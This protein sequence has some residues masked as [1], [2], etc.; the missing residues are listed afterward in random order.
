MDYFNITHLFYKSCRAFPDRFAIVEENNS[1]TYKKLEAD[2]NNTIAYFQKKGI[3]K[4]DRILVFVGMGIDLYRIVLAIFTMGAVAVFVDEW[5]SIQRLSL[6]CLMADCKAVIAPLQYRIAGLF[7]KGIRSI[8]IFLSHN[9]MI[10]NFDQHHIENTISSDPALI[11][12]TTGSTGIPKAVERSHAFLKSQFDELTPLIRGTFIMTTLPIV[13]LLNLGLGITSFIAKFNTKNSAGFDAHKI[14]S[15]INKYSIDCIITSPFYLLK[16]AECKHRTSNLKYIIS[17][18]AAIFSSDAEKIVHVFSNALFTVVYGSTEAEPISHCYADELINSKN[19]FGVQVGKPVQSIQLKIIPDDVPPQVSEDDLDKLELSQGCI[20]EIIVSGDTVNKS[21]LHNHQAIV[22]NKIVT[23]KNVWHRTGD[24][25][26]IDISGNLFL[27]GRVSQIIHH[28]NKTYYPFV[29]ENYLKN[30]NGVKFGTLLLVNNTLLL[31]L[32]VTDSF[33][34]DNVSGF[35]Y[36]E[37]RYLD[38]FP[39]DPRHHSK[40][41]YLKLTT[42]LQ[43]S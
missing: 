26:Y 19:N 18:G 28:N 25:G 2:V 36:D 14:L 3:K 37:I 9:T 20:G 16:M 42:L 10:L 8:P 30:I 15:L 43:D 17:G 5:V 29:V 13:L 22:E 34:I 21:Y 41:D 40:I 6:C 32:C 1:I 38:S 23:D 12:F 33:N 39:F 24:S 4:G 31:A 11:T 7:V 27:T 35:E